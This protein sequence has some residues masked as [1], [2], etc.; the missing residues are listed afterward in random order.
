MPAQDIRRDKN[1][2]VASTTAQWRVWRLAAMRRNQ[3]VSEW[4]RQLAANDLERLDRQVRGWRAETTELIG[5][6]E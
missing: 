6:T 4:F 3:T 1:V 2:S 5:G